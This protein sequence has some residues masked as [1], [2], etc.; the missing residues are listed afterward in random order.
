MEHSN[1]MLIFFCLLAPFTE[2]SDSRFPGW[3]SPLYL[4]E[5]IYVIIMLKD[6]ENFESL[7]YIHSKCS[8]PSKLPSW[9]RKKNVK[10]RDGN[11][12]GSAYS[13]GTAKMPHWNDFMVT[14]VSLPCLASLWHCP[15]H[16]KCSLP[17]HVYPGPHWRAAARQSFQEVG[18]SYHRAGGTAGK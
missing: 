4:W 15:Q 2:G 6:L 8:K 10:F 17:G 14:P 1:T 11:V 5:N 12:R 9:S 16:L 7:G 18:S 13:P 3:S